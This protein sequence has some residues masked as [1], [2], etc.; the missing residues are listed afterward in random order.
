MTGGSACPTT[1][2]HSAR[3]LAGARSKTLCRQRESKSLRHDPGGSSALAVGGA[4]VS[5]ANRIISRL[6]R[7]GCRGRA[8]NAGARNPSRPRGYPA[9]ALLQHQRILTQ[10]EGEP[11]QALAAEA[12]R[13][14]CTVVAPHPYLDRGTRIPACRPRCAAS[15]SINGRETSNSCES[16]YVARRGGPRGGTRGVRRGGCYRYATRKRRRNGKST[17]PSRRAG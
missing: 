12:N 11:A 15:D 2:R 17:R 5:P 1:N 3:I 6:L 9:Y 8:A 13:T 14:R 7:E 16:R 10:R 4:A